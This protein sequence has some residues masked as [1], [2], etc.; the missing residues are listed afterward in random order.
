MFIAYI[1]SIVICLC[2]I[3]TILSIKVDY[4]QSSNCLN[5]KVEVVQDP[6]VS[7]SQVVKI[8]ERCFYVPIRVL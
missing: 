7:V 5:Y 4:R 8:A 3:F 1:N 6:N 2:I